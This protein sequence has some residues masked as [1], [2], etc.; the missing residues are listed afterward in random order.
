MQTTAVQYKLIK[1]IKDERFDE[2]LIHQYALILNVGTRDFQVL[3]IDTTDHRALLLEDYVL[4]NINSHQSL[5][6]VLNQIFDG[7]PF[8]RAG[9]WKT[10]SVSVKNHKFVQVPTSLFVAE[11]A[12]DYLDFNAHF[13]EGAETVLHVENKVAEATTVYSVWR[14]LTDWL[15]RTYP[16][17]AITFTHQSAALIDGMLKVAQDRSENPLYIYVDRFRLH[18]LACSEGKLK[19]YNQFAIKQFADYVKY[20][21]LVMST[22]GMDQKESQVVLWGYIGKNS[23]HYHEFYKYI[24]NVS[25]GTRGSGIQFGYIFDEVQDHHFFDLFSVYRGGNL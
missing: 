11:A 2:E 4:P 12:A 24:Q 13:E 17:K 10:I 6:S 18:V 9:F 25:F 1:K 22:L 20:I 21:M 7:H 19:Y 23:P 3:V 8:L 14:D 16:S 5:V 15:S